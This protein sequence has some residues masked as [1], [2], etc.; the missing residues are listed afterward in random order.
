MYVEADEIFRRTSWPPELGE[1]LRIVKPRFK[2]YHKLLL[3]FHCFDDFFSAKKI[4]Y[5]KR[6][7]TLEQLAMAFVMQE[8]FG[9]IWT[10]KKWKKI[11]EE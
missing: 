6:F 8:K 2:C 3:A 5:S 7:K 10:G 11:K 1:I 9:K 4:K